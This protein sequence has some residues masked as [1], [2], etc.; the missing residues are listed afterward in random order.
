WSDGTRARM[1]SDALKVTSPDLDAVLKHYHKDLERGM[2]EL[3]PHEDEEVHYQ[4]PGG[5]P[6]LA[7]AAAAKVASAAAPLVLQKHGLR[8]FTYQMGL[9]AHL[10]ADVNFPLNA[11]DADPREALYR[12]AYR[13]YVEQMLE[14]I[15]YVLDRSPAPA[16]DRDGIE[17]YLMAGAARAARDY[18]SIG[19]AFK[20]DGTP[21][22]PAAVDERSIP[23]GAASLAYSQAVN[24]IVRLWE[25]VWKETDSLPA[26]KPSSTRKK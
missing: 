17:P 19:P 1:L 13:Q 23:F 8:K 18:K 11:S 4:V 25:R 7:A 20:D 16:L 6:G 15:P 21:R 5:G 2:F 3:T 9:L 24:D 22:S 14:H 12:D 26:K 10:V